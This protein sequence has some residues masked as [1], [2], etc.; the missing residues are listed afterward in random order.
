MNTQKFMIP[1]SP[2]TAAF[3]A[4]HDDLNPPTAAPQ[5]TDTPLPTGCLTLSVE[6][7]AVKLGIGR[8][9]AYQGVREGSIPSIRIGHRIRVPV[10]ALARLLN[11]EPSQ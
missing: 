8:S 3:L 4:A 1:L 9:L 2:S 10:Q 11:V 6:E 7:A 5:P